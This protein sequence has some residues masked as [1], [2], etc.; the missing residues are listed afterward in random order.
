MNTRTT[1]THNTGI[2]LATFDVLLSAPIMFGCTTGGEMTGG[3]RTDAADRARQQMAGLEEARKNQGITQAAPGETQARLNQKAVQSGT[4][5]DR[6]TDLTGGQAGIVEEYATTPVR[7]GKLIDETTNTLLNREVLDAKGTKLRSIHRVMKDE[8]T[9]DIEYAVVDFDDA[10]Y[11][12]PVRWSQFEENG[13]ALVVTL[14]EWQLTRAI[15]VTSPEDQSPE[16]DHY[17]EQVE[18]VRAE[19]KGKN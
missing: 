1:Y 4:A 8:A 18:K 14:R 19:F 12:I 16:L 10:D 6:S 5:I 3:P 13:D 2:K 17:M 11:F 15:A 9:G 7:Q